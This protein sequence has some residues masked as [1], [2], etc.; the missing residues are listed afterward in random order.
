MDMYITHVYICTYEYR[1]IVAE[2]RGW[3]TEEGSPG[4][5][6]VCN[7]YMCVCVCVH[8]C[9]CMCVCVCVHIYVYVYIYICMLLFILWCLLAPLAPS[10]VL[11]S[12]CSRTRARAHTHTHT[13]TKHTHTCTQCT[14]TCTRTCTRTHHLSL[15]PPNPPL[16]LLLCLYLSHILRIREGEVEE[17][18]TRERGSLEGACRM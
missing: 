12:R 16:S 15:C 4:G 1:C 5:T 17:G 3:K 14:C 8:V 7:I 9:V 6:G 11:P 2:C 18:W 10:C 13:H